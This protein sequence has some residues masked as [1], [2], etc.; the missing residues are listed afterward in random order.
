MTETFPTGFLWGA[1]TAAYQIEGAVNSGWP[2]AVDL[3]HLFPYAGPHAQRRQRGRRLPALRARRRGSRAGQAAGAAA[4]T[5][6]RSPGPGSSPTAK[7][8]PTR[9]ASIS[10]AASWPGLRERGHRARGH[11]LPLGPASGPG[12][13]GRLD[14]AGH[15]GAF[16]RV[17]RHGGRRPGGRSR[18]VDHL[19]RALV[20]GLARLRH[21]RAR[22][23]PQPTGRWRCLPPIICCWPTPGASRS[24]AGRPRPPVGITLNLGGSIPASDHE[25]DVAAARR[26][27]GRLN[28]MYLDPLFKG[29]YPADMDELYP[30]CGPGRE[31]RPAGRP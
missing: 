24:C 20:L 12:G 23:G 19:E 14:V 7:A 2:W 16:R 22:P 27:D 30:A 11:P 28:R 13:R 18:D 4:L 26:A 17:R 8:R 3:G 21:R 29:E 31:R 25:L 9:R 10:T 1:A 6:S 15:G 5:G